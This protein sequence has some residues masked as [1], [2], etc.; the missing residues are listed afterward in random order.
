MLSFLFLVAG[1]AALLLATA[2]PLRIWMQRRG[3]P[4][5][6]PG[7]DGSVTGRAC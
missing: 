6:L 1:G 5:A 2:L 3:S 7:P 4:P